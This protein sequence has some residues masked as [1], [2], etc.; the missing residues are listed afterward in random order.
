MEFALHA[1]SYRYSIGL[2][3]LMANAAQVQHVKRERFV[4]L[5]GAACQIFRLPFDARLLSGH[6][7]P[8]HDRAAILSAFGALGLRAA[9]D[10]LGSEALPALAGPAFLA[11]APAEGGED[12]AELDFVLFLRCIDGRIVFLEAGAHNSSEQPLTDLAARYRGEVLQFAPV[13]EVVSDP[14]AA[15]ERAAY[16][17]YT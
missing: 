7:P 11:V 9:L 8:P 17:R 5:A 10:P 4:W 15:G 16:A 13:E 14:D 12:A 1:G 3:G 2:V 6:Y